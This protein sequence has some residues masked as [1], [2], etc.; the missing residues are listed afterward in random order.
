MMRAEVVGNRLR[1]YFDDGR[2][3]YTFYDVSKIAQ[4]LVNSELTMLE[5]IVYKEAFRNCMDKIPIPGHLREEV[6]KKMM[7]IELDKVM[8]IAQITGGLI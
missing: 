5:R 3:F 6:L 7:E 1:I 4:D 2:L 8:P